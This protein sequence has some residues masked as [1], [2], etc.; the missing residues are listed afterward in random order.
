[1]PA[2]AGMTE[3][4][5]ASDFIPAVFKPESKKTLTESWISSS[6]GIARRSAGLNRVQIWA[7]A[8]PNRREGSP[9]FWFQAK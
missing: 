2:L 5:A 3:A 7:I 6:T 8:F 1:M 9:D 4:Y